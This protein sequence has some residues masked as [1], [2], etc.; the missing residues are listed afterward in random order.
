MKNIKRFLF[1]VPDY[2]HNS[3]ANGICVQNL[4]NRIDIDFEKVMVIS[5][6]KSHENYSSEFIKGINVI[7]FPLLS[8]KKRN[9]LT[10]LFSSLKYFF[11]Y[12]VKIIKMNNKYI[13]IILN[14]VKIFNPTS[15][16]TTFN[17]FDTIQLGFYLKKKIVNSKLVLYIL[18]KLSSNLINKSIFKFY[19]SIKILL[20]ESKVFSMSDKIIIMKNDYNHYSSFIYSKFRHLF[21][22]SDFPLFKLTDRIHN[23]TDLKLK[24]CFNFIYAGSFYLNLRNPIKL[25]NLFSGKYNFYS[26]NIKIFGK[27]TFDSLIIDFSLRNK[28]ISFL[29]FKEREKINQV[30]KNSDFLVSLGNNNDLSFPSKIIEY[31]SYNLPIIHF[32]FQKR[33]PVI[34]FLSNFPNCLCVDINIQPNEFE[35]VLK[36][37]IENDYKI[38]NQFELDFIKDK[39]IFNNPEHTLNAIM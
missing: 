24:K 9:F 39:L 15:I 27:S 14:E 36:K 29:G 25:L 4:I 6:S 10:K 19:F 13:E 33:D 11:T 23:R 20:F 34:N 2:N 35:L 37:F 7:Y 3:S 1:I 26:L 17:S 31:F 16:I 30:I 21:F 8:T 12:P 28:S 18:D 32:Y 5:F 38:L 22:K